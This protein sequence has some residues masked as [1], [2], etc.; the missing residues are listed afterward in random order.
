MCTNSLFSTYER[1]VYFELE[2][3]DEGSIFFPAVIKNLYVSSRNLVYTEKIGSQIVFIDLNQSD[4]VVE[5]K[6]CM[7]T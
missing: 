6:V 3:S 5:S 4:L 1:L 7:K 2:T